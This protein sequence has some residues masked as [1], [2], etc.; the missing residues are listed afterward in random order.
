MALDLI[1]IDDRLVH[2]QVVI[3]WGSFL[4]TT[5][6]ILCHDEIAQ[7]EYE[8]EMYINAQ[9]IAP[10]PMEICVLTKEQT[11]QKLDKIGEKEEKIMLLVESPRDALNLANSGLSFSKINIGGLHFQRGKRKLAPYIY[12]DDDDINCLK[13][14]AQKGI[15]LEGRDV[16]TAKSIDVNKLILEQNL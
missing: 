7:S 8:R 9:D 13:L 6:I 3:A 16:P 11:L 10:H 2:G 14:L 4:K 5:K 12:V 15:R 1:R